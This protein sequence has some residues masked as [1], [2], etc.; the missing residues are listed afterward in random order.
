MHELAVLEIFEAVVQTSGAQLQEAGAQLNDMQ[1]HHQ[2]VTIQQ[3]GSKS[4]VVFVDF[5]PT[6]YPDNSSGN[7]AHDD[8]G[9]SK[10][11]GPLGPR[12]I[13]KEIS[14]NPKVFHLSRRQRPILYRWL[15]QDKRALKRVNLKRAS[16]IGSFDF[17]AGLPGE[18]F[19]SRQPR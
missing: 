14:D 11:S 3:S 19:R 16:P 17:A 6:Y 12:D 7:K 15:N 4:N 1:P 10:A 13:L 5:Q 2:Y 9:A 8:A 18:L